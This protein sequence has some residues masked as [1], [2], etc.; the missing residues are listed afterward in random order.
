MAKKITVQNS[1]KAAK[2][3]KTAQRPDFVTNGKTKLVKWG[4]YVPIRGM[5][6]HCARPSAGK[7]GCQGLSNS[8]FPFFG[9]NLRYKTAKNSPNGKNHPKYQIMSQMIKQN[10]WNEGDTY[11][12]EE[13]AG[14]APGPAPASTGVRAFLTAFSHSLAKTKPIPEVCLLVAPDPAVAELVPEVCKIF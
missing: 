9:Q 2:M 14:I 10:L 8:S 11:R 4:W 12:W 13:W 6:R 7:H 3:A 1:Q 5:S